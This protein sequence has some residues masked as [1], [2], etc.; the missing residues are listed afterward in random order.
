MTAIVR[1]ADAWRERRRAS[2]SAILILPF[3]EL[4]AATAHPA[5]ASGGVSRL[6]ARAGQNACIIGPTASQV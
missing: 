6:R 4:P 5:P 3:E 1:G 2:A